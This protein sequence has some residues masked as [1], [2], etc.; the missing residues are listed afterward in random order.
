MQ[1]SPSALSAAAPW[2][3]GG[4]GG[5]GRRRGVAALGARGRDVH[6]VDA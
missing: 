2:K 6:R 1:R 3:G 5:G 4:G